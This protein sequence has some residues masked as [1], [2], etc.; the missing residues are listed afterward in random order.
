MRYLL[1]ELDKTV[2]EFEHSQEIYQG[3]LQKGQD[4]I[5]P[6]GDLTK[7]LQEG[8]Q[9][10][11]VSVSET[12]QKTESVDKKTSLRR[13]QVNLTFLDGMVLYEQ[14]K[15]EKA[16]QLWESITPYLEDGSRQKELIQEY[17]RKL[18]VN[19]PMGTGLAG[20]PL[21]KGGVEE[22]S[23]FHKSDKN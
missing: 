12:K 15:Y 19:P 9:K 17:R 13:N 2:R 4:K 18:G 10:M 14:G 20:T 7:I 6:P 3:T 16:F 23:P 8:I 22:S 1:M 21:K 11:K 5:Q